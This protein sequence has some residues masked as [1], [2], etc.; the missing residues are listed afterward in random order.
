MVRCAKR[1]LSA[2]DNARDGREARSSAD[3]PAA[4][5]DLVGAFERLQRVWARHLREA[6]VGLPLSRKRHDRGVGLQAPARP[7]LASPVP[8]PDV[9]PLPP[10]GYPSRRPLDADADH[11][12]A[13]S[14]GDDPEAARRFLTRRLPSSSG[15]QLAA[16]P[17]ERCGSAPQSASERQAAA[18]DARRASAPPPNLAPAPPT[19]MD[20]LFRDARSRLA[21]MRGLFAAG[22]GAGLGLQA[23]ALAESAAAAGAR[24]VADAA[25]AL[26]DG[27]GSFRAAAA[28]PAASG[29]P[30]AR[31]D[32]SERILRRGAMERLE[33]KLDATEAIWRSCRLLV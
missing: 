17:V 32:D 12:D 18:A 13:D 23:H 1:L 4:V 3:V 7:T 26:F 25:R 27:R 24:G 33:M 9:P 30:A 19:E 29:R 6:Q 20:A 5:R 2:L 16:L 22:D 15:G 31:N 8:V 11:C 10:P 28:G 14:Q 21:A